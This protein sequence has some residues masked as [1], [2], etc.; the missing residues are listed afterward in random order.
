MVYDC[1]VAQQ[2]HWSECGRSTL[3]ADSSAEGRPH[4]SVLSF[5]KRMNPSGANGRP[6]I[7]FGVVTD[8]RWAFE[9]EAKGY[10]GTVRVRFVGGEEY[11]LTFYDPVRLAQ[12]LEVEGIIA[13]P[14]LVVVP[15]VTEAAMRKSILRLAASGFFHT[16]RA[17][18]A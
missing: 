16:L 18:S 7:D 12:D 14:G 10:C 15:K 17:V 6:E 13:E 8:E 9:T 1:D 11:H 5:A 3:L 4:R 2:D